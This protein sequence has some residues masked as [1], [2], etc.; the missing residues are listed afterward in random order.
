MARWPLV[1][2]ALVVLAL[3]FLPLPG[4]RPVE[5]FGVWYL[6]YFAAGLVAGRLLPL[7][8][9]VIATLLTHIVFLLIFGWAFDRLLAFVVAELVGAS[10][11]GCLGAVIGTGLRAP[12][13][14]VT[15]Q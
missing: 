8:G 4:G 5:F 7:R 12:S 6:A 1:L 9:V 11:A 14:T 2:Y 15:T 10:L 13:P 3:S